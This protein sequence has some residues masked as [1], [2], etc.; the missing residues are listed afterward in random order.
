[1]NDRTETLA[2]KRVFGDHSRELCVSSTK[3]QIGHLVAAAGAVE[4]AACVLALEHQMVPPTI[5]F[6][7]PDPECDLDI[8]PNEA[9]PAKLGSVLSN[10]FGFGGQNAS[11]VLRQVGTA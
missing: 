3:S 11:I 2:I 10:S 1:M 5:N 9:R 8:V 4:L 7:D 6:E